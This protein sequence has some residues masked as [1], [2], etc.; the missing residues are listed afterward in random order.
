M[1]WKTIKL[2]EVCRKVC[3]GGTPKSTNHSYYVGGNIP[4]LNT[5]EVNFSYIDRTEGYITQEGLDN[6]SA[7]WIPANCVIV[8][9]YGATAG[10][11]AINNIPLT[12]NQAC[13]NLEIDSSL[14]DFRY[15]YY[16]LCGKYTE[17]ASL[18][19]GGAQQNLNAQ[20][21]KD[22]DLPLPPLSTQRRIAAILSS[23]DAQ[24]ENNNRINRN[25]EAQAQA[26]F[27][28]WFVDF[29]PWGGKMPDGWREGKLGEITCQQNEKAKERDDVKVLSPVTT[30]KLM[31]SEEYFTKQVFSVSIAKYKIVRPFDFAYNPARV[32]IGSLGMNEFGFDGCVSPV[33]VVFSCTDGYEWFFDLFRRTEEFKQEVLSRAIGGVR[34]SLNYEDFAIIK[35]VIPTKIDLDKFNRIYQSFRKEIKQVGNANLRLAALRDTLLPKL[36]K[37]EIEV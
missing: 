35:C 18:A 31:L 4:W 33:Y 5:K 3:S 8:A 37:G 7:K 25:L 19:N 34:Q 17:L 36:M 32:N 28:S 23:L 12:T 20:I 2:G 24:I 16:Y 9:M 27:K 26:L 13:C 15:T 11:V 21:I 22:F 30:G 10:K 1:E 6:S 29:E 14:A